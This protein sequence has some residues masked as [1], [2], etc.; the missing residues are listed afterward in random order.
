MQ[1]CMVYIWEASNMVRKN[2]CSDPA[3]NGGR[4]YFPMF[5]PL[6]YHIRDWMTC[7]IDARRVSWVHL[8]G[9]T[10]GNDYSRVDLHHSFHTHHGF[11]HCGHLYINPYCTFCAFLVKSED[12]LSLFFFSSLA[13]GRFYFLFS[14]WLLLYFFH[15]TIRLFFGAP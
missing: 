14:F 13:F 5:C 8:S 4:P 7:L 12:L 11:H 3:Q 10:C 2:A 9:G 15:Y 6:T 1:H